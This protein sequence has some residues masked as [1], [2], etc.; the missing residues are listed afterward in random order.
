LKKFFKTGYEERQRKQQMWRQH[1]RR[2]IEQKLIATKEKQQKDDNKLALTDVSHEFTE[3]DFHSAFALLTEG[4][5]KYNKSGAG[6]VPLDAFEVASLPPHVFREQLKMVFNVKI[7]L[8]QLWALISYFDKENT[9]SVNCEKFLIQFFRT[10][11]EERNRIQTGWRHEK[12]KKKE[13]DLKK[14]ED[15]LTKK[16]KIAWSEVDFFFSE[17]DF[18]EALSKLISMCYNF[19]QRQVGPAGLVAFESA[20]LNPAEFREMLRRT[21]NFKVNAKELGALVNYFDISLKKIV[22]NNF[23]LNT[24]VQIRVRCEEFKVYF[25]LFLMFNKGNIVIQGEKRRS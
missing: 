22:N 7:S 3:E 10:G 6:S 15:M 9:G 8:P 18:D 23:F 17:T 16:A 13:K 19:D 5:M 21:F 1:Q 24:L 14:L 11:Y 2:I 20:S 12:E 4:A 25:I